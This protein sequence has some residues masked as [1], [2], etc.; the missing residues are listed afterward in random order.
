[1][2]CFLFCYRFFQIQQF[3]LTLQ[4]RS[5]RSDHISS[6]QTPVAPVWDG[7]GG[8]L[9]GG[10]K[11]LRMVKI[12]PRRD[13]DRQVRRQFIARDRLAATESG[14]RQETRRQTFTAGSTAALGI[15]MQMAMEVEALLWHLMASVCVTLQHGPASSGTQR[16]RGSSFPFP[17]L[18]I[19][20]QK[21]RL[22]TIPTLW[23]LWKGQ[24]LKHIAI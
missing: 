20:F 11:S 15:F 18:S 7:A 19:L 2:Y 21:V 5:I 10:G 23:R 12:R 16:W 22:L 14:W 8:D 4:Q 1:M 24:W 6:A 17:S 3:I 13:D 9:P